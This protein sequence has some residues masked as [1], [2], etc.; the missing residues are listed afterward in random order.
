M[1]ESEAETI[2]FVAEKSGE[3]LDAAAAE[4]TELSRARVQKLAEEGL[5]TVGGKTANKKD[6]LKAGDVVEITLPAV[7]EADAEP[8]D[9]PLEIV[10]ED[11]DIVV[12]NKPSGMVVHPAPGHESGTLV[13][14]L[15]AHCGESLSGVGGVSRPGIVHRI[16]R[17]TSGLICAAKNDFSH[18]ALSEQLKDHSMHREYRM[19]V[20]GGLKEE[21]GT[22][23]EPIGRHPVDRK[24]MAVLR[25]TD[26]TAREAVTH[27]RVLERFPSTGFTYAA[28]ELETGRTHQIRVHMAFIGHPLMGDSL[29]GGGRTPFERHHAPLL[30]GQMLHAAALVLR[31]PRTGEDMRF[32]APL[33]ENFEKMLAILRAREG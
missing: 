26:K 24:K 22:V 19:L 27:W 15:L 1:P 11:A 31:H 23:D 3:R 5:I 33:P 28:A 29:Y 20:T 8:E 14:A 18:L 21:S 4:V 10:Y 12:V 30:E 32:E 17:E 2:V 13:N 9:I 16:D 6:K 7:A 25:G